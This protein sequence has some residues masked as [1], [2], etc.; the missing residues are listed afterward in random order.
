MPVLVAL[1]VDG[2]EDALLVAAAVFAAGAVTDGLDGY[3]A[4]RWD[5]S[6]RT[7]QWLDPLADKA[8]VAAPVV[9]LSALGRFPV[10]AAVLI[11]GR[12]IGIS[13]LRAWLGTRGRPMPA[14]QAAKVKTAT[15]LFAIL[16]Y[17]LPLRPG[18]DAVKLAFLVLAVAL[19]LW[20]GL[21]YAARARD[22]TRRGG[23]APR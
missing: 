21:Q 23:G 1:I 12:E 15:Q 14:S 13:V 11:I 18:A 4:R 7:G 22:W 3:L 17:I 20:T 6:T 16:L 2:G 8:L 9:T 5:S 10:W 19:T